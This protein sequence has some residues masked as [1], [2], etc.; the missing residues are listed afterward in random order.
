MS[1]NRI[2]GTLK[3]Y[4]RW[5]LLLGLL[6]IVMNVH[7]YV[8]NLRAGIIMSIY[9]LF[10][11]IIASV[12]YFFKRG[13][14]LRN[15]VDYS[16]RFHV[17]VNKLATELDIPICILDTN[18]VCV[19]DNKNFRKQFSDKLSKNYHINDAIPALTKE[20]LPEEN[21]ETTEL[22]FHVEETYFKAITQLVSLEKAPDALHKNAGQ[23]GIGDALYVIYIYDETEIVHYIRENYDQRVNVGL[24]YIDNYDESLANV[25]DVRRS[26]LAAKNQ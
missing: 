22:H 15:L 16:M 13:A 17:T 18:G 9:V 23:V 5:P 26:L 3:S 25:D 1:Q 4:L 14:V 21:Y 12:L 20:Y 6:L 2:K 8:T 11:L 10:Y 19:W 7:I 24:L